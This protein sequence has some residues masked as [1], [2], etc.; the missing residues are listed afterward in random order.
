MNHIHTYCT[1]TSK[2]ECIY[3]KSASHSEKEFKSQNCRTWTVLIQILESTRGWIDVNFLYVLENHIGLCSC[4]ENFLPAQMIAFFIIS[5]VCDLVPAVTGS[6]SIH[7]QPHV[8][9][10]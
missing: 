8:T 1:Y 9:E 5:K 3:L 7:S 10:I 6:I 2:M 4:Q